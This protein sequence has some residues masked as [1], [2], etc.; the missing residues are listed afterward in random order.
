MVDEE[1]LEGPPNKRSHASNELFDAIN[2]MQA[3][4]HQLWQTCKESSIEDCLHLI[5]PST[6][7]LGALVE[8]ATEAFRARARF[9]VACLVSAVTH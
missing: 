5:G 7:A 8:T 6:E 1:R 9:R 2:E 3:S 4:T